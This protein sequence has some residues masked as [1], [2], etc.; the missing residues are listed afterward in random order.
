[1]AIGAWWVMVLLEVA[2]GLLLILLFL[3]TWGLFAGVFLLIVILAS[4]TV[5]LLFVLVV[6]VCVC[7][8]VGAV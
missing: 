3:G 2:W 4:S 5:L 1:M 7:A 6:L 8:V